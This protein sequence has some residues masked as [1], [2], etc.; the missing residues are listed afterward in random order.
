ME[1][2]LIGAGSAVLVLLLGKLFEYL[3]YKRKRKDSLSDKKA[4]KEEEKENKVLV[5][6]RNQGKK[7]EELEQKIDAVQENVNHVQAY[8]EE[9]RI[10]ERRIRILRFADEIAHGVKHS[11]DHFQQLLEDGRIYR[12]YVEEHPD[13]TNG[14]TDPAIDLIEETYQERFKKNDFI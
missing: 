4:D 1:S 2:A 8:A 9:G 12:K 6:L 13:F 5:E 7:L 10:L 14:I 3:A 11:K